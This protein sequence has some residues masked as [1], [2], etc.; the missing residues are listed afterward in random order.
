MAINRSICWKIDLY[1][2][3]A[4]SLYP[5]CYDLLTNFISHG[6]NVLTLLLRLIC[7]Q[8][9]SFFCRG[10]NT[11]LAAG[12]RF[13]FQVFYA[14]PSCGRLP[15]DERT[16]RLPPATYPILYPDLVERTVVFCLSGV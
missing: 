5:I 16:S 7:V 10:A 11:F 12:Y 8:A 3:K 14:F 4:H 13:G 1:D 9:R 2:M 6:P 15:G